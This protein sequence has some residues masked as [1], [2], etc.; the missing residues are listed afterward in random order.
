MA[1]SPELNLLI[2]GIVGLT[3]FGGF[4]LYG[5]LHDRKKHPR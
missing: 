1:I 3:F 5:Y 2:W 4:A